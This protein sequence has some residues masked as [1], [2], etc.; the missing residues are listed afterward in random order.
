MMAI[1]FLTSSIGGYLS[2]NLKRLLVGVNAL[3]GW[4]LTL[5]PFLTTLALG[6]ALCTIVLSK[7]LSRLGG[8]EE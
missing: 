3:T 8:E 6:I 1:F 2:G 5:W 4:N 7:R